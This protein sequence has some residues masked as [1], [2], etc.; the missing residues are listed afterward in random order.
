MQAKY[1][2]QK[3]RWSIPFTN[4]LVALSLAL[5]VTFGS[6]L[7]YALPAFASISQDERL[8]KLEVKFFKHTYP[9]DEDG[10]R[11]ERL[12][13]M[14]FGEAK[15]GDDAVRLKNLAST[16]PNLNDLPTESDGGASAT[17]SG[18]SGSSG[19]SA[20]GDSSP[21]A[22][23]PRNVSNR[24]SGKR[25]ARP[26][27]PAAA[28]AATP[29]T[30]D[31]PVATKVLAGESKYP[32]VT[33]LEQHLFNRDYA[34]DAVGDRLNRL[35]TKVFGRPSRFTDLSE[36]VDALK[37]KTNIDIAKQAPAGSDWTDDDD[38]SG[39]AFPV[40]KRNEPVAR[41]DGDD[42]RSFS[43]RDVGQDLKKAFGIGAGGSGSGQASGAF[44]MGGTSAGRNSGN[45]A[46]GAY[47]M[48]RSSS[49]SSSSGSSSGNSY[50]GASGY[51]DRSVPSAAD[52]AMAAPPSNIGRNRNKP[53]V[54]PPIS[55]AGSKAAANLTPD[56]E[57]SR[58]PVTNNPLGLNQQVTRLEKAVLG[59]TY[60]QEP[61][62]A[63]VGRLEKTVFPKDSDTQAALA[64]PDRVARLV[65]KVPLADDRST[66]SASGR[67]RGRSGGSGAAGGSYKRPSGW[68]DEDNNLGY[69]AG[70]AAS[71]SGDD[72]SYSMGQ[73]G[74]N[75]L[76]GMGS[77][78]GSGMSG[79]LGVG[80]MGSGMSMGGTSLGGTTNGMNS[81]YAG[82]MGQPQKQGGLGKIINSLGNA[83]SG[84][85]TG[86]Y[87]VNQG[88]MRTDPSTG[89]LVDTMTGNLINPSTGAVVGRSAAYSGVPVYSGI[90]GAMGGIPIGGMGMGGLGMGGIGLGNTQLGGI[91]MG[92][93]PLAPTYGMPYGYGGGMGM[94]MGGFN[95]FNNGF[96]PYG[97]GGVSPYGYG[98]GGIR[99][100][101]VGTGVRIGF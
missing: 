20:P 10:A 90:P 17:A 62:I 5:G 78:M 76:S 99:F 68:I 97:M 80:G 4:S 58:P 8:S 92:G 69:G 85:F 93:V 84:G 70:S 67:G 75:G 44:G 51:S 15:S 52:L 61:L 25:G 16:V 87:N 19:Q 46:S 82:N 23:A 13:K 89:Y 94:P 2:V 32:A 39:R 88:M 34:S 21:A 36:R 37:E 95:G 71:S 74:M 18:D 26:S 28:P 11:L 63:R 77:S 35:E 31:G 79:G 101:G 47:G 54:A 41:A 91:G 98:N 50:N 24:S 56:D 48:G 73:P 65:G 42:G 45:S 96:S 43:G 40:P 64:L 49:S 60:D 57:S 59:K 53:A 66:A 33:A 14:I 7:N 55:S 29:S 27:T 86:G 38:D 3:Y 9:K 83:L 6:G 22:E 72:D 1:S 12:E 81:V 100:G 30:D